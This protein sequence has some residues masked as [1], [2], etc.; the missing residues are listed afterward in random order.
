MREFYF[1]KSG[2]QSIQG[3]TRT[4]FLVAVRGGK[5]FWLASRS[6]FSTSLYTV[7]GLIGKGYVFKLRLSVICLIYI[8][9]IMAKI[10]FEIPDRYTCFRF[11][12]VA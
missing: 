10:A 6:E 1:W 7:S 3:R 2:H 4:C 9:S 12:F 8:G 11:R 5:N